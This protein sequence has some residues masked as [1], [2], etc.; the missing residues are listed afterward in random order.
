M[1][2]YG[3]TGREW[4]AD[5][6]LYYYRNRWY[7]PL[8]GRFI[9]EDP[10]TF[11]GGINL[12]AYVGNNPIDFVDPTGLW[13]SGHAFGYTTHQNSIERV[14]GSRVSRRELEILKQEQYD[15]DGESQDEFYAFT[16]AMRAHGE[17]VEDARR[18]A[19]E[20]IRSNI[21]IARKL[22]SSGHR[23]EAMHYLGRAM[24]TLQDST[25]PAHAGF[26]EAWD[27]SFLQQLNHLPHYLTEN[28]DP[29]PCSVLDRAT[30]AVYKYFTGELEMPDNLFGNTFDTFGAGPATLSH[31][32][33]NDSDT[34]IIYLN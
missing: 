26:E 2:R 9:S 12:Y 10:I 6:N 23:E 3:Y 20:W 32:Q 27:D 4:D 24:H 18:K 19:N 31:G 17:S 14:L 7:D 29:G 11:E 34:K 33:Q 21:N 25:S 22:A 15:W 8:V 28:F 30:D 16:H 1:T 5:S 13:P